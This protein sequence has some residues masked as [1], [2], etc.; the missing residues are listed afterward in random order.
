MADLTHYRLLA[1]LL[2]YPEAGYP[3]TVTGIYKFI[4]GKYPVATAALER[5]IEFLPAD[6][7]LTMQELF[8]RSFDVQAIATLDIGY[9]L[10]GD[11]YKRGELLANLNHEHLNANNDCG[12]ELADYLPNILRL[13]SILQDEE[14]VRDLA[15]AIVA[16]ALLE[17]IGEFDTDRIAKKNE[18]YQKHYKTLIEMPAVQTDEAVTLYKFALKSLY[19]VMKQDFSLIKT[20]PLQRTSDFL[21]SIVQENEIEENA[22]ANSSSSAQ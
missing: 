9:V 14:L 13:M 16:P 19:E 8:T 22:L 5:F 4:D 2:E 12:T 10:F 18:S 15:Y 1:G 7:L 3:Q 6:D 17:M 20:M 21:G 11:D